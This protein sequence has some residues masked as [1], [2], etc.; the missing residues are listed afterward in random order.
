MS[1]MKIPRIS[2]DRLT[3]EPELFCK[4]NDNSLEL[5]MVKFEGEIAADAASKISGLLPDDMVGVG[6]G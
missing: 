3:W 2:S 1:L 5:E 6:E 4:A